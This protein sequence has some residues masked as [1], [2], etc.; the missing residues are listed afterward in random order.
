M[1]TF[2]VCND[3]FSWNDVEGGS[4]GGT[5]TGGNSN[6]LDKDVWD[7]QNPYDKWN[8]LTECEK[9]FFRSNPQHLY[10]A[11]GN[12]TEAERVAIERF[13]SCVNPNGHPLRNTIGDAHECDTKPEEENEKE[14]DLHNNAWGYHYGSTFSIISESQFYTT[15]MNAYNNGQI[16]ILQQCL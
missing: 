15:F 3:D 10:T 16:K 13:G 6:F 11:R 7:D 5:G 14:M 1:Y 9:D 12:R 8:K 2:D 4:G